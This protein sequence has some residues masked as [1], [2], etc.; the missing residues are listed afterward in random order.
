MFQSAPVPKDGRYY[1]ELESFVDVVEFQS[2]PVPKDGRYYI[3]RLA[4]ERDHS[5]FQSAPVP[6]DGRY[7]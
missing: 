2:A 7:A 3:F 6:K 5:A 4:L 1:M